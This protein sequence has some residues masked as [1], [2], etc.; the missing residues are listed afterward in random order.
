MMEATV[1][2]GYGE[3][4]PT[5]ECDATTGKEKYT[6]SCNNPT[7]MNG[8]NQ[9]S[10]DDFKYED[11]AVNGEW[12]SWG[13]WGVCDLENDRSQTR[14][15]LFNK[16]T[17]KNGGDFCMGHGKDQR[18]C[19]G[20]IVG[21]PVGSQLGNFTSDK[22]M[23]KYGAI[24]TIHIQ[25]GEVLNGLSFSY[26]D[27]G[28]GGN[29]FGNSRGGND[30]MQL[31]NGEHIIELLVHSGECCSGHTYGNIV[32]GVEFFTNKGNSTRFGKL[33]GGWAIEDILAAPE[34]C[35]LGYIEGTQEDF[36]TS[37]T[38]V[39]NCPIHVG[40]PVGS[41]VGNFRSD[42]DEAKYGAITAIHVQAGEVLNGLSLSY[43]DAGI[44]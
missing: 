13:G 11:C 4:V 39:W 27:T 6:R 21:Q 2:G 31:G 16:P 37:L 24:M 35:H 30:A 8:G 44:A 12:G 32:Y 10:N 23:A 17:P 38:P 15:R 36:I 22:D 9:C 26:G 41:Q 28:I 3:F 20:Q 40:Q 43:G 29:L 14:E 1:N 18:E 19:N 25:A 34:G 5:G 42:K 7:P 33:N